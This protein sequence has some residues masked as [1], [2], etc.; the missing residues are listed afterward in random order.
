MSRDQV[1]PVEMQAAEG[2]TR[3]GWTESEISSV[4]SAVLD[5]WPGDVARACQVCVYG[6]AAGLTSAEVVASVQL[7]G[8]A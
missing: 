3:S 2:R 7:R 5:R 8:V 1:W 4:W 6:Q